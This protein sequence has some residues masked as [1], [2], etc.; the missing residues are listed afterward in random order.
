MNKF[1]ISPLVI[2]Y[3]ISCAFGGNWPAWRGADATGSTEEGNYPSELNLKK[4]LLW[5]APLPD[6]GCSTPIVWEDSILL[7][8]PINGEDAVLSF[9]M[10]GGKNWQTKIGPERKGASLE[11]FWK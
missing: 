8:S 9:S 11:W 5:K 3:S 10:N 2:L 7:T 6:K 4:N 1:L